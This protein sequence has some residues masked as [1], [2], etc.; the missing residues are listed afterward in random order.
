MAVVL[1]RPANE[2]TSASQPLLLTPSRS[3]LPLSKSAGNE[4]CLLLAL[5]HAG[6]A[7]AGCLEQ[8]VQRP[9][10]HDGTVWHVV[11][12]RQRKVPQEMHD[13]V[14][15]GFIG[16]LERVGVRVL[17]THNHP[18]R[19][20]TAQEEAPFLTSRYHVLWS[21]TFSHR[22]IAC[23]HRPRT[24]A[25]LSSVLVAAVCF[26]KLNLPYRDTSEYG[27]R[28]NASGSSSARSSVVRSTHACF[29]HSAVAPCVKQLYA[30]C[31]RHLSGSLWCQ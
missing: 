20:H 26:S 9:A 28:R 15:V 18:V 27:A 21:S 5:A 30:H 17:R 8:G 1:P 25:A 12:R 4:H 11:L 6:H 2:I 19:G 31:N 10:R 29:S 7:R 16:M 3:G 24:H 14:H 13:A 22:R 23:S